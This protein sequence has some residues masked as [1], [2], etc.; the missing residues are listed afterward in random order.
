[1]PSKFTWSIAF[2]GEMVHL[3]VGNVTVKFH[4]TV[5]LKIAEWLRVE[6]RNAKKWSGDS[7]RMISVAGTLTDAEQNYKSS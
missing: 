6:G 3:I 5:A 7:G 2:E 4:F 1:M